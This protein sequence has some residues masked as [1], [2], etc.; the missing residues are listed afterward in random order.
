MANYNV[1]NIEIGVISSSAK[2][3]S[4][5]DQTIAKLKEF[6]KIDKNLQ[7]I[8]LRINQLANGLKKLEKINIAVLNYQIEGITKS[9]KTL[10]EELSKIDQPTFSETAKSLNQLGNAFRQFDKLKDFDFRAMYNSFN[11]LNRIITPFL[12]KL[13][14]SE[15]SLVAMA[16]VL[17]NLKT[18]TITKATQELAKT[19]KQAKKL[20]STVKGIDFSKI[21]NIGK[22]YFLFNYTKRIATSFGNMIASA[23]DFNETLNK[24]QVS[25]GGY[26]SDVYKQ[27]LKFVEDIT[28]AFNLS[29][30]SIMNYMSTFKNMLSA[31][32]NIKPEQS[33]QLSET[34]TRMA[35]DYASL[36]N[37][38]VDRAMEQFQSVLSGQIRTIRSVSGYDVSE[39]S[40]YNVYKELGGTKTMRQLD[41]MEKRLLRIIALQQQM[42][43]TGAVS[44]FD[45][46]INSTANQ[47]KQLTETMKE[48]GR[49]IGELTMFFIEPFIEKVLGFA[50]A[51]REIL[52]SINIALGYAYEEFE[53]G[54][55]FGETEQEAEDTLEAVENLK[56]SML[57]FDKINVLGA[58]D[59]TSETTSNYDILLSKIKEYESKV[60]EVSNKANE[61]SKS[62][63][64]WL[65][66]TYDVNGQ[67]EGTGERL[68]GILGIV[69]GIVTTFATSTI[70]TKVSGLISSITAL[71]AEGGALATVGSKLGVIGA[72][73][74]VVVGLFATL[75]KTNE[76]FKKSIDE[77]I[78]RLKENLAPQFES[79]KNTFMSLYESAKPFLE[80]LW[81]EALPFIGELLA[82]SI[83]NG[84]TRIV[85][86]F[87]ILSGVIGVV[88]ELLKGFTLL[89]DT[90]IGGIAV[91]ASAFA[92]GELSVID[93]WANSIS[94][95]FKEVGNNLLEFFK[96]IGKGIGNLFISSINNV[97]DIINK[98]SFDVPDWIPG[99]GGEHFG[100]SIPNIP[101]LANGGIIKQP[102]VAMMG[103]Y[104]GA[105]SNPEIVTPENLM[106]QV[107]VESMLPIAQ[108]IASG[109]NEVVGA[110]ED[111]ANRPI[112]MNGRKVSEAIYSDLEKVSIRKGKTMFA[113]TG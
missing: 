93:E 48:I 11:S 83:A 60:D 34:L 45:K 24:F 69:G 46:T 17:N 88:W 56:R 68:K 4:S 59:G 15:A 94:E 55:L 102:T 76:D 78:L 84:I 100:F 14:D 79:I 21:F 40:I 27:S 38:E 106:R 6:K 33:S 2:A 31:F 18:K 3:L 23:V 90:A 74:T 12:Q 57:G 96:S 70:F 103:E 49:W 99:I 36:F 25:M 37:V 71:G 110:I 112:E 13:K 61:I 77:I 113:T 7:D 97:I 92:T 26:Q 82:S 53:G 47:F 109:N 28:K 81:N 30:E 32:G 73:V 105:N 80:W 91:F 87:E 22:I 5:L 42:E 20:K 1:G 58:T 52:K 98:L 89:L 8:F 39:A 16:S 41:Q 51:V 43:E 44:D 64:E 72:I 108:I 104:A 111:L 9:T 10:V 65:G 95:R 85:S 101:M 29:T 50:I 19:D 67:L 107:F 62:I 66:Y 54:G 63:L 75:Y 86:I 35:L